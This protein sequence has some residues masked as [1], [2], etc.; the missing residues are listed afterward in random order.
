MSNDDRLKLFGFSD[1]LVPEVVY[2][3]KDETGEWPTWDECVEDLV[4][5]GVCGDPES[6]PEFVH[7][8]CVERLELAIQQEQAFIRIVDTDTMA[9]EVR[10]SDE[11][12]D[13]CARW[14]IDNNLKRKDQEP[15]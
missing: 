11:Q 13:R 8:Q 15:W 9:L 6:A 10:I 3:R 7:Q 14:T 5:N 1:T 4:M 12:W 2:I